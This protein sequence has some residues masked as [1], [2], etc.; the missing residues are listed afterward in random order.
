MY[1]ILIDLDV[2]SFRS[3]S[4]KEFQKGLFQEGRREMLCHS[5]PSESFCH[6]RKG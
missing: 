6:R 2:I 4:Q 5:E 3:P 1:F